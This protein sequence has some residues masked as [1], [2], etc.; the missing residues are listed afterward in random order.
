MI[1]I[2]SSRSSAKLLI[3]Q[4]QR[5]KLNCNWFELIY[6]LTG[7]F[8]PSKTYLRR[9]LPIVARLIDC[10]LYLK[11]LVI[12]IK[13]RKKHKIITK[14]LYVYKC[15]YVSS[16]MTDRPYRFLQTDGQFKFRIITTKNIYSKGKKKTSL[17]VYYILMFNTYYY[18]CYIFYYSKLNNIISFDSL[19]FYIQ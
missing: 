16:S 3:K 6:V 4:Y 9:L 2:N 14:S 5:W 15:L 7:C 18:K 1:T 17:K 19:V 12:E 11:T 13:E 10:N 8:F